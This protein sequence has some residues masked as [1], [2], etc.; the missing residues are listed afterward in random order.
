MINTL[1]DDLPDLSGDK[2]SAYTDFSEMLTSAAKISTLMAG[3]TC[4]HGVYPMPGGSQS[5]GN[6]EK[7]TEMPAI[8]SNWRKTATL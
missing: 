8:L 1:S 4:I 5:G 7:S 6:T 3:E 2:C